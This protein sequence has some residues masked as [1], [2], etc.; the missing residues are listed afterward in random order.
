MNPIANGESLKQVI[1]LAVFAS[2]VIVDPC[3]QEIEQTEKKIVRIKNLSID[4][5]GV[6]Y[7]AK[8]ALQSELYKEVERLRDL[9]EKRRQLEKLNVLSQKYKRLSIEPLRWRDDTGYPKLA[10]F[11]LRGTNFM[12]MARKSFSCVSSPSMPA[13]LKKCYA[14]V[15]GLLKSKAKA[16]RNHGIEFTLTCQFRGLIPHE[17]KKK[18][19]AAKE[20]GIAVFI[21]AEAKD[22][23]L[24]AVITPPDRDPLVVGYVPE[25]DEK[26]FWL[27]DAFDTTSVEDAMILE[28]PSK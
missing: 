28:L 24:N 19:K 27:I 23:R 15:L 14:D 16:S 7:E 18:I 9:N 20:N 2:P 22:W 10:I 11:D 21:I 5:Y 13:T 12:L 1:A 4:L 8:K 17:T 3:L 6:E 25:V 26:V